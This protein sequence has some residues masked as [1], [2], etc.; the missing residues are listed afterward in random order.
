MERTKYAVAHLELRL[1]VLNRACRAAVQAQ[2]AEAGQLDRP[3]LADRCITDRQVAV[4]LQRAEAPTVGSAGVSM[5]TGPTDDDRTAEAELRAA[6]VD[7]SVSL[8]L[9]EL[10]ARYG[11]TESDELALV[12]TAAPELDRAYERLYAYLADEFDRRYPSVETL[13]TLTARPDDWH[14]RRMALGPYGALR[15]SGLLEPVGA[16]ST[17]LRQELRLAPGLLEHIL[18]SPIDV[19]TLGDA[20]VAGND[21]VVLREHVPPLV[22][23]LAAGFSSGGLNMVNLWGAR[24]ATLTDTAHTIALLAGV[25]LHTVA[26][27]P[28]DA[29]STIEAD[30]R[31]A[32]QL[33]GHRGAIA[34]LPPHD[35][36]ES[37]RPTLEPA[38]ASLLV[39]SQQPVV[40]ATTTPWRSATV[41]ATRAFADIEVA[42]PD[43]RHRTSL[44]QAKSALPFAAAEDLAVRF[45]LTGESLAAAASYARVARSLSN[46]DAPEAPVNALERACVAVTAGGG[47][48]FVTSITP[49]RGPDDLVVPDDLH[50][51]IIDIAT[52][53]RSLPAVSERWG[54]R[55]SGAGRGLKVLFVGEPGTGKTLAA[56]VIASMLGMPLL[57]VDLA[58]VV[59]K[60]VGE[61]AQHLDDVFH[62]A[63]S[64]SAVLF[65]DE[66]DALFGRRAEVRHGTDRYANAEVSHLLQRFERHDGLVILATNLRDNLDPAMTRRFHVVAHF[67]RPRV[68]DRRRLWR[69]AFPAEAP[70]DADVDFGAL[71]GLD[72]T[73]ASIV[74]AARMAALIAADAGA[75]GIAMAHVVQG[76]ARQFRCEARL[77]TPAE[78]G[79][80]GI[81][82]DSRP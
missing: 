50:R 43:T 39:Q 44:W 62:R 82:L 63:A 69:Q 48:R 45:P 29:A 61:T 81:L 67:P 14:T 2:M 19:G 77:I 8:P 11:L 54:F 26:L 40:V 35:A 21:G 55:H 66:A 46:G 18:G 7:A 41:V 12:A 27:G 13:L 9:D 79:E 58:Q 75:D 34:Y 68:E 6:A 4:L 76:V 30:L 47:G 52:F 57:L 64:R 17:G 32:F 38:L 33:A 31:H 22:R 65:F 56:E 28:I 49:R 16:A 1:K 5:T 3:E 71:A 24:P 15:R 25:P 51:Q 10:S 20:D 59:S 73:G 80:H 78:L 23:R 74:G 60:W 42:E 53:T 72:M 37:V 70:L 36:D